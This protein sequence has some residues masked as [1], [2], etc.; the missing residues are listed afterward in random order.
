[1]REIIISLNSVDKVKNFVSITS[2]FKVD[3]DLIHDRYVIDAKSIMGIFSMDLSKPI[4]LEIHEGKEKEEDIINAL[5][6]Y[7][8][9]TGNK[10]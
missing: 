10:K 5:S 6:E 7:I 2:K 4:R 9:E 1:M 3:M 8:I